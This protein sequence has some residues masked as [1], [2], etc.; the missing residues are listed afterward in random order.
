M[1]KAIKTA[2]LNDDPDTLEAI[3]SLTKDWTRSWSAGS[4]VLEDNP[5]LLASLDG[6]TECMKLLHHAGYRIRLAA[7]DRELVTAS[8]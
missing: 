6:Y 5:L 4:Q 8:L 7:S 2:T 3:L 1:Q